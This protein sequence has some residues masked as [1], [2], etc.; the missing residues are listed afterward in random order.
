MEEAKVTF[1]SISKCGLYEYGSGDR[2]LGSLPL[3]LGQLKQWVQRDG[4]GLDETCTYEPENDEGTYCYDIVDNSITGDFL[5]TTWNKTP[6]YEG[7][8]AAVEGKSRVGSA[9]VEFT[10]LPEGTIPGYA[11]Y[12][13][14]VPE[15]DAFA[16]IQFQHRMNGKQNLDYYFKGFIAK[17]SAYAVVTDDGKGGLNVEGYS[18]S[19]D[20]ETLNL[21]P[22]YKANI[23]RKPGAF[24]TILEQRNNI[25]KVIRHN[26]L[27]PGMADARDWWEKSLGFMGLKKKPK[28]KN[29]VDIS[30]EFAFTPSEIE[31]KSMIDSW[32]ANHDE[33]WDDV[34]FKVT[35]Y[36]SPLW[37]S[38]SLARDDFPLEVVRIDQEIVDAT[39]ILE[40]LTEK[41]DLIL[42]L[43]NR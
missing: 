35:G 31:L 43:L 14:F 21:Y 22:S 20:D 26:T 2:A 5:L 39:S 16:T 40:Q 42:A 17:F 9:K 28:L 8:V 10:E 13:W 18:E 23:L 32:K 11:T 30:Y 29:E 38:N 12:F 36:D 27:L 7:T 24:E 1:Y 37:L 33:K 3:F 25:K 19:D 6:S 15:K 34:G 41:R 4:K